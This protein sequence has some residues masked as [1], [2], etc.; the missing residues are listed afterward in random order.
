MMA[1]MNERTADVVVVGAGLAGLMA[2]RTLRAYGVDVVVVEARDRVG[3]RTYSTHA[4]D[5]TTVIDL[6]GQW[7]GPNQQRLGK[8]AE[9]LG[10]TTFL[11]HDVGNNIQVVAGQHLTYSG[12]IPMHDPAV[13]M[14]VVQTMLT[15]NMM[16]HEVPLAAPWTAPRA[17]EWDA[18]TLAT[19]M[20][21]NVTQPGARELLTIAIRAIFGAEPHDLAL[22]HVLFYTHS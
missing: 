6:G 5:G 14:E 17:R 19:W 2:A 8:L 3:G 16:A 18:Q 9:E 20:D 1:S 4:A 15:L 10:V 11:T 22:L 7:I 13:T 21:A 12:A